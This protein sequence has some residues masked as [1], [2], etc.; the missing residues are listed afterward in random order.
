MM[1]KLKVAVRCIGILVGLFSMCI[2]TG[3][4]VNKQGQVSATNGSTNG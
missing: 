1:A 3:P 2:T 4:S